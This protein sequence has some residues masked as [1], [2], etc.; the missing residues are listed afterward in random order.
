MPELSEC[1]LMI[2]EMFVVFEEEKKENVTP[3]ST[4]LYSTRS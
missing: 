3:F 2:F 4:N 1:A